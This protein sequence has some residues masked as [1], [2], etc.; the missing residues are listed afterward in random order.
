[1]TEPDAYFLGYRHAERA[2]L[3]Q[4]MEELARDSEWL[5]DR[6][7]LRDGSQVV[8]IGCGPRGCLQALSARVGDHGKVTGIERNPQ[9]VERARQFAAAKGLRNVEVIQ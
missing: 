1:M 8:E 4:P 9:E 6:L 2:R 7:G 3:E 5:F